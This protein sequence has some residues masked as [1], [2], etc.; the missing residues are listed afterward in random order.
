MNTTAVIKMAKQ[1]MAIFIP[2]ITGAL[3]GQ[4][5]DHA[6][7]DLLPRHIPYELAAYLPVYS[8]VTEIAFR[9]VSISCYSTHRVKD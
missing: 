6:S 3:T 2:L 8:M 1:N 4:H 7:M 5:I 9:A